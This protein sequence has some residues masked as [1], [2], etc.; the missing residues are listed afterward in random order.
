MEA[1]RNKSPGVTPPFFY[2]ALSPVSLIIDAKLWEKY[3]GPAYK[4]CTPPVAVNVDDGLLG[5]GGVGEGEGE[6]EEDGGEQAHLP[7]LLQV[8]LHPAQ[9]TCTLYSTK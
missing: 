9:C 2:I 6:E 4:L 8:S 5:E 1:K 3:V 7:P